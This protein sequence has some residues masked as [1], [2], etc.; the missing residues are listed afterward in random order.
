[1]KLSIVVTTFNRPDALL[2]VLKSIE[3][4]S[5]LPNEVIIADD[6]S[7]QETATLIEQYQHNTKIKVTHV[8]QRNKGFRAARSRNKAIASTDSE[9]II[10]IDGD[11]ILH[12]DF[13]KD[14][15]QL[16][17]PGFFIQGGRTLISKESTEIALQEHKIDFSI[18]SK[19]ISNRKN[20]IHSKF[21]SNLFSRH[22]KKI[23]GIKSCNLSF[24]KEDCI[25]VNGFN[26]DFIGWGRED[27]EFVVRLIN[28]N[29]QR[30]NVKFSCIQYHLWHEENTRRNLAANEKY[31]EDAINENSS[32]CK[33]GIS[34]FL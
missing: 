6:G 31:L 7:D 1:M 22:S 16:A 26:N 5:L 25:K 30:N 20:A 23:K 24:Y 14:H 32:Y 9:Y 10:L 15:F 28:S 27:S 33:N 4:Q 2:L 17:R 21:L 8:W 18:W 34:R 19:G 29:V 3:F 11:M 13:I 12:R